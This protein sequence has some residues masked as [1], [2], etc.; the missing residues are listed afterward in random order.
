MRTHKLVILAFGCTFTALAAAQ[1]T[2]GDAAREARKNKPPE[3]TTK[4]V[5]NDDFGRPW[6]SINPD[7]S[8]EANKPDADKDKDK[9]K[10]KEKKSQVEQQAELD[11]AWRARIAAQNEKISILE[12]ELDVLQR[13][14]RLRASSYYGDAGNRLRNPGKYAE[15][16]RKYREDIAAKQKSIEDAKTEL[17]NMREQARKAG[18]S[19][20]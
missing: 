13:E 7:S 19:S 16:D 6:V 11:K 8:D 20:Q 9:N 17:D 4:V 14:N 18:A 2:L 1:Q 3:P 10:E 12:R 5:T 15:D